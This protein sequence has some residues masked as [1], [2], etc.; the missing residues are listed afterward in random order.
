MLLAVAF[1]AASSVDGRMFSLSR[2]Y[3]MRIV[4]V[5]SNLN[6]VRMLN[7]P[8][9][10]LKNALVVSFAMCISGQPRSNNGNARY[11]DPGGMGPSDGFRER[12]GA[13]WRL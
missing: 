5:T 6:N 1:S 4:G 7:G 13:G 8:N 9:N 3:Y 12:W 2:I 11:W 10:P